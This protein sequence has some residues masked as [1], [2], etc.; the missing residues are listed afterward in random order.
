M[1]TVADATADKPLFTINF[2]DLIDSKNIQMEE[3]DTEDI[4]DGAL[5]E[6]MNN[7]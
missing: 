2:S 5:V 7:V 4:P 6:L 1:D 3:L